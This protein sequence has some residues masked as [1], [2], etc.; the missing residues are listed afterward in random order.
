MWGKP[1]GQ[2][3]VWS[4]DNHVKRNTIQSERELTEDGCITNAVMAQHERIWSLS[5]REDGI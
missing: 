2:T 4:T 3:H 5:S 1:Q